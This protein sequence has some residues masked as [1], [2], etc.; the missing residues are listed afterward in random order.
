MKEVKITN[1]LLNNKEFGQVSSKKV[2]KQ[3]CF[4]NNNVF[5]ITSN[6][7]LTKSNN[8]Y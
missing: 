3:S 5:I 7:L 6:Y 2:G 4:N 1:Q 8:T